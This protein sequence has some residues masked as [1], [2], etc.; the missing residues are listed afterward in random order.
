MKADINLPVFQT[1]PQ[2]GQIPVRN[3]W[4]LLL[5]AWKEM[6]ALGRWRTT[7]ESA[8]NLDVLLATILCDILQQRLRIGLGR[9][10][11]ERVEL[12]NRLRGRIDFTASIKRQAFEQGRAI[13]KFQA[14]TADVP[15]NQIIRSTLIRLAEVGELGEAKTTKPL[16]RRLRFLALALDTVSLVELSP[17]LIRRQYLMQQD[18]DYRMML[19]ICEMITRRQM[20]TDTF[21]GTAV[22]TMMR[23]LRT[24]SEIYETF[25]ANFFRLHLK[26][27]RVDAQIQFD[28]LVSVTS[29]YLPQM[30][31][32]VVL[33]KYETGELIILDTKFTAHSLRVSQFG[34]LIFDP[35]HLYQIYAYLRSQENNSPA[36]LNST[37]ILLYP[38]VG[39]PLSE[40]IVVQGHTI[41]FETLD[42]AK[43]WPDIESALL[44]L[45]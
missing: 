37:G 39:Y 5:Y 20:P 9:A 43:P 16:R 32:D 25:V 28:W 41:R 42:L 18:S 17:G 31:P 2:A 30:R 45:I 40:R 6:K 3:L 29:P 7:V 11:D 8:P 13:C 38:T 22:P 12:L 10:Y 23:D 21:G 44:A 15:K 36:H 19:A 33:Q 34:K 14:L 35:S 4:Y 1:I 27:W 24:L 26:N